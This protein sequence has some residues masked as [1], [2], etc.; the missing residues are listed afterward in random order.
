M[1]RIVYNKLLPL[2]GF[3]AMNFFGVLFV[4][5]EYRHDLGFRDLNHEAIHTAQYKELAYI[6]FLFLY[7]SEWLV[8]LFLYR[9]DARKAYRNLSFEREAYHNEGDTAY[10]SHRKRYAWLRYCRANSH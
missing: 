2:K 3:K 1:I 6:G 9:F 10:L 7:L 8:K 4:R 5:K